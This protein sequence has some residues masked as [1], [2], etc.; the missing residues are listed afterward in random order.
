MFSQVRA[1]CCCV[2]G[3]LLLVA[4]GACAAPQRSPQRDNATLSQESSTIS[5]ED[6]SEVADTEM[7]GGA[8]GNRL[9]HPNTGAFPSDVS[10]WALQSGMIVHGV[11][12]SL[13]APE[14][15]FDYDTLATQTPNAN[16]LSLSGYLT[17]TIAVSDVLGT[18]RPMNIITDVG[19]L[20]YISVWYDRS[21]SADTQTQLEAAME[22]GDEILVIA[23]EYSPEMYDEPPVDSFAVVRRADPQFEATWDAADVLAEAGHVAVPLSLFDMFLIDG[24]VA[25]QH[26]SK[27]STVWNAD[28]VWSSVDFVVAQRGLP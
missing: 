1:V 25:I 24:N 12:H 4:L 14:E 15:T 11:V 27:S 22:I 7:A 19:E 18:F 10:E 17:V 21:L 13:G 26:G 8:N 16:Q 9:A 20:D 6:A 28:E 2:L 5:V 3:L 23:D